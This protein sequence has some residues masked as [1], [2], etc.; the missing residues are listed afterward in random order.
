ML[1][2]RS[3]MLDIEH[4]ESSIE[5]RF[6]ANKKTHRKTRSSSDGLDSIVAAATPMRY[7]VKLLAVSH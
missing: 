4:P 3:W 1:D 5:H 7:L 2:T 6:G